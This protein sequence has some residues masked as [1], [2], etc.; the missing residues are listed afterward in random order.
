MQAR[1]PV[2]NQGAQLFFAASEH[3]LII[4]IVPQH[5]ILHTLPNAEDPERSCKVYA[6]VANDQMT[7]ADIFSSGLHTVHHERR[8][9]SCREA[10]YRTASDS[11]FSAH[12]VLVRESTRGT[13]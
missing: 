5:Q 4:L 6:C 11:S 1:A 3:W 8:D 7:E 12:A 13:T 2:D 10:T 9:G